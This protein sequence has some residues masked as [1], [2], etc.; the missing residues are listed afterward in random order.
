MIK[1]MVPATSANCCVGFD[2]LGMALDWW[3][4]FTFEKSD[5]LVLKG[6]RENFAQKKI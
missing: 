5:E 3:A 2:A 6:A 4:S 1:V